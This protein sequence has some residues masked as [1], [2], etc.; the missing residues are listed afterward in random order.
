[1]NQ[2][3]FKLNALI[4]RDSYLKS[5][6]MNVFQMIAKSVFTGSAARKAAL[7]S[8]FFLCQIF[9]FADV[10]SG[11]TAAAPSA[12]AK[13]AATQGTS[14]VV[15]GPEAA[16]PEKTADS[17]ATDSTSQAG[18]TGR[19]YQPEGEN[20]F[21]EVGISIAVIV[22][23][24]VLTW[25]FSGPRKGGSGVKKGEPVKNGGGSSSKSS[26]E[27]HGEVMQRRMKS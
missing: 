24:C 10:K 16:G 4:N 6:K 11:T 27:Q 22:V 2:L 5:N 19:K 20:M 15:A 7:V 26:N 13:T 9:V 8:F 14:T 23:I 3:S 21:L 18:S 25:M 12:T 1:L 17:L